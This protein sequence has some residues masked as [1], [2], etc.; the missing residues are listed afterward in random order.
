VF[1]RSQVLIL[2]TVNTIAECLR[3]GCNSLFLGGGGGS[4]N[5]AG[6]PT[7]GFHGFPQSLHE[8]TGIVSQN[9]PR[10]SSSLPF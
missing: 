5:I 3:T 9:R 8:T 1:V 4:F 2:V 10:L 6:T 7:P